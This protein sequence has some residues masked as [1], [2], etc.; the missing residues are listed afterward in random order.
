VQQMVS[1]VPVIIGK[2]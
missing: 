2:S 1:Y